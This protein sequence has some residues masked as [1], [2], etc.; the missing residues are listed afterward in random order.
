MELIGLPVEYLSAP[1]R[2]MAGDVHGVGVVG[3]VVAGAMVAAAG[4]TD[5]AFTVAAASLAD[6]DL[7]GVRL[8]GSTVQLAVG[9]M[10]EL[11]PTAVAASTVVAVGSTVAVDTAVADTAVAADTGKGGTSRSFYPA[12]KDESNGWQ[13]TLLAV[14][15]WVR[16]KVCTPTRISC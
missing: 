7:R 15:S 6:A 9:F 1:A 11:W 4:A 2:G 8:A 10:A 16:H 5:V 12:A 3:A 14:S 13:R